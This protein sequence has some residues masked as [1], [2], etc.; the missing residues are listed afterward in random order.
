MIPWY[1]KL[2]RLQYAG[3]IIGIMVGVA[4]VLF[5]MG[6][7]PICKCGDI[8]LWH[9][10]V[11]SSEN[12]QHLSDWYTFT[13]IL[14]GFMFY[15]ILRWIGRKRGWPVATCLLIAVGLE[16]MWEILENTS[17]VIN[18]YRE[19]TISLDYFGDSILN[20]MSDICAMMFGFF[21]ASRLRTWL[22][23]VFV[24]VVEIFLALFIRDNLT[25]NLIMLSFPIDA[26]KNW[27]SEVQILPA[28]HPQG[29]KLTPESI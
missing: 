8:K 19:T 14:H 25:I 16:G 22:S 7:I 28:S 9:G 5:S 13:H 11:F 20:S 29:D 18:R 26:I 1:K 4:I 27:Q 17:Y 3:I 23:I 10:V 12:S 21:L 24:V 6:R 15:A 2:S